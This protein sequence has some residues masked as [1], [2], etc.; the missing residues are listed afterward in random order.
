MF[1]ICDFFWNCSEFIGGFGEDIWFND[2]FSFLVIKQ[3]MPI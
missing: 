1:V 2:F 3:E